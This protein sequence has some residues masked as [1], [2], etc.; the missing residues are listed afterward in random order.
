MSQPLSL[1]RSDSLLVFLNSRCLRK[2]SFLNLNFLT[3]GSDFRAGC[4]LLPV[5]SYNDNKH[6][7]ALSEDLVIVRVAQPIRFRPLAPL[8]A[9][10]VVRSRAPLPRSLVIS[11][12]ACIKLAALLCYNAHGF[13]NHILFWRQDYE[14]SNRPSSQVRCSSSKG[15]RAARA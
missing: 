10:Q 5:L 3:S 14:P 2:S 4:V 11:S 6:F 1:T 7:L 13:K 9:P 12:Q 15:D 8:S